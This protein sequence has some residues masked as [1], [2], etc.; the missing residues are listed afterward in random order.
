MTFPVD[1]LTNILFLIPTLI[2][3]LVALI[4]TEI[5]R[6]SATACMLRLWVRIPPGPWKCVCCECC[7]LSGRGLCD[8]LITRPEES[9]RLWCVVVCDLETSW[10]GRLWPTG[11]LSRKKKNV[12]CKYVYEMTLKILR[13]FEMF[14]VSGFE[15]NTGARWVCSCLVV[16][17]EF[18]F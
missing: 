16:F 15:L 18:S 14:M 9:Y 3:H 6:R 13:F 7:V 4:S 12:N 17:L 5:K 10:M 11:G 2:L 1:S 8:G